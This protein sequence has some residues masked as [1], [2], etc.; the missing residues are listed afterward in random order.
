MLA[1]NIRLAMYLT[2]GYAWGA[3]QD[4]AQATWNALSPRR[5]AVIRCRGEACLARGRARSSVSPGHRVQE[6]LLPRRYTP[7]RGRGMPR[8]YP[9]LES[10]PAQGGLGPLPRQPLPGHRVCKKL[11][12][13]LCPAN[14]CIDPWELLSLGTTTCRRTNQ[15]MRQPAAVFF[16]S[17]VN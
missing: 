16:L 2:L 4:F 12:S 9:V 3:R 14:P 10:L 13:T 7:Q 11:P 5:G 17:Y 15:R 1:Y 8:P 6:P